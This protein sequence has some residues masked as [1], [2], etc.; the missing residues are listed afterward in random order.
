MWSGS[1]GGG[2]GGEGGCTGLEMVAHPGFLKPPP[3]D[4]LLTSNQLPAAGPGSIPGPVVGPKGFCAV[5]TTLTAGVTVVSFTPTAL[6]A[7]RSSLSS[8][9]LSFSL[10][11][12]IASW[13]L[14]LARS[15][16]CISLNLILW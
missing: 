7:F 2:G 16:N 10:R 4:E 8:L 11:L 13:E 5:L 9:F 1:E 3:E 12:S 14:A 15:F 6:A